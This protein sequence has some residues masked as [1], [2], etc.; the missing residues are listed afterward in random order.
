[1]KVTKWVEYSREVEIEIG[2]DDIAAALSEA[3]AR[4]PRDIDDHPSRHDVTS[5]LNSIARFFNGMKDEHIALLTDGQR[6][7]TYKFLTLAATRFAPD[8]PTDAVYNLPQCDKCG[9]SYSRECIGTECSECF[10]GTI[11][12]L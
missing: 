5:A 8:A 12:A 10:R 7:V 9:I 3:F 2:A 6:K 4:V 1:M 11:R